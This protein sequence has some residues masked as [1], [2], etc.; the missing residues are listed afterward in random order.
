MANRTDATHEMTT[1]KL[2]KE[3]KTVV[4]QAEELLKAGSS[5]LSD[6][7]H[8]ARTK[9]NSALEAAKST[10]LDLQDRAVEGAKKTDTLI[11]DNP[12]QS[13]GIAFGVGLLV[14]VLVTRK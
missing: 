2:M 14:G 12:Y 5:D 4:H 7:G 13:M 8:D 10:Y 1:Q 6:A 9:L 3:L 11:R